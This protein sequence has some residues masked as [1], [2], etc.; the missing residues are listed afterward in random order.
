MAASECLEC[1]DNSYLVSHHV[2]YKNN[3]TVTLCQSCHA[4]V[5]HGNGLEHLEPDDGLPGEFRPVISEMLSMRIESVL[6]L[7]YNSRTEFVNSAVRR[8]LEEMGEL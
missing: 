4:T 5:H 8:R 2:S 6:D 3:E 7:G 1:G